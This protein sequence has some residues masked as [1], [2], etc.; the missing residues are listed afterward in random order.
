MRLD[1]KTLS[2]L[3]AELGE[4]YAQS[5]LTRCAVDASMMT[6]SG[7]VSET[8]SSRDERRTRKERR[9]RTK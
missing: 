8:A 2:L 4:A 7:S 3:G 1:A 5:G 6:V 9:Q